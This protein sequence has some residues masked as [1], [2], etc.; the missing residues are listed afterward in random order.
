MR[1][2]QML[3]PRLAR[4]GLLPALAAALVLALGALAGCGDGEGTG[5]T[6]TGTTA[7]AGPTSLQVQLYPPYGPDIRVGEWTLTCDPAGGTLPTDAAA[8][9][10]ALLADPSLLEPPACR[11]EMITDQ[12]G[13][14]V[15]GTLNGQPVDYQRGTSAIGECTED[16][17]SIS[18]V[19]QALG[20]PVP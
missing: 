13:L 2:S 4:R 11:G 19:L 9:C 15:T 5:G 12:R 6:P 1:T 7:A 10:Q 20:N 8:A 18:A 3:T 14:R 16:Q 17:A